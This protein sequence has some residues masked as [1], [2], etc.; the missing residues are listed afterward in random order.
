MVRYL[1]HARCSMDRGTPDGTTPLIVASLQG[2]LEALSSWY[3]YCAMSGKTPS[4]NNG[5]M[6]AAENVAHRPIAK[7]SVEF[8]LGSTDF[9]QCSTEVSQM[10]IQ[11]RTGLGQ[12]W[13]SSAK[14][15]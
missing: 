5:G 9:D 15:G 11:N 10:W 14:F 6:H 4:G 1:C 13:L 3:P 8:G 12:L 2:H 7:R